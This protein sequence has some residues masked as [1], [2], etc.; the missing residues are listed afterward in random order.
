MQKFLTRV[1]FAIADRVMKNKDD[2]AQLKAKQ[3]G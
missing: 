3:H 2:V 1:M